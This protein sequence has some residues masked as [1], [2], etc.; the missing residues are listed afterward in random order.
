VHEQRVQPREEWHLANTDHPGG[1]FIPLIVDRWIASNADGRPIYPAGT[2][3]AISCAA[4]LI[5]RLDA[6]PVPPEPHTLTE[7]S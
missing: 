4:R 2:M 6:S 3:A 7:I 1:G 5:W